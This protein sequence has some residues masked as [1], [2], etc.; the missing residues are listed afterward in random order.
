MKSSIAAAS[1][2]FVCTAVTYAQLP[3]SHCTP[4]P[5]DDGPALP[6]R[7]LPGMGKVHFPISTGSEAA[8]AFF[9]QGV[10]QMHSFWSWEAERSF[11]QAAALD[12][13]APMP[14][15]GVAMV[16]AGD[17]RPRFQL[18][19]YLDTQLPN[20]S[21][22]QRSVDAARK[23]GQLASVPGKATEL[24]KM[25]IDAILARRDA[26]LD[27]PEEAYTGKL[28]ALVTVYPNEVEART[29]LALHLMRG[30]VL[31]E[32]T[33]RATTM[34]AVAILRQLMKDAPD[35]PGVHHYVIHGFEGST[36]ARDAFLSCER[37]VELAPNI[38]HAEH[39]PG[40][41]YSQTGRWQ[42][43]VNAFEAAAANERYWLKEDATAS[44]GHHGHNVH[45]LATAY[46][47]L[48]QYDKA[49]NAAR[50]LLGYRESAKEVATVDGPRIAYRQGW[51]AM[52]RSIVQA[53]RWDDL[54][55]LPPYDRPRQQA[56]RHWAMGLAATAKGDAATARTHLREMDDSVDTLKEAIHRIPEEL[57]VA[58]MELD[59]HID[60]AAGQT[61]SGI[62][63]LEAAVD[64]E[65]HMIYGEPP[66]YPRPAA[67]ALG[68][69]ALKLGRADVAERAFRTALDQYE[70]SVPAKRGLEE[71][72]RRQHKPAPTSAALHE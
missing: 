34:E 8:Q 14:W 69:V 12:P 42:D 39:M 55:Q 38:P 71:A 47:F 32:K 43:A 25:Y 28:R 58:R 16:A 6:A 1:I 23:A 70:E 57:V 48:G 68:R 50:E 18:E 30:Y 31:P 24:E 22:P 64:R 63:K 56:W 54:G 27:S 66:L 72:L 44:N 51:F 62:A 45:Y 61:D 35:H 17:F 36:F 19:T 2:A 13:E 15:W 40:H 4:P 26:T 37:Y 49:I 46:S 20:K 5:R 11:R 53:E 10:A 59:G 52:L 41:I 9:D 21:W 67:E 65:R 3:E 29:Y 33:P 60:A 7:I